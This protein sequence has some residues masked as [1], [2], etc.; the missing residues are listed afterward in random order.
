MGFFK[1][2][3]MKKNFISSDYY[4][5]WWGI[6]FPMISIGAIYYFHKNIALNMEYL[7]IHPSLQVGASFRF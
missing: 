6:S 2:F 1:N 7:F 5:K 3:A 4:E